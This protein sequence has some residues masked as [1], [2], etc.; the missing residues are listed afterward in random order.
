[1]T[2]ITSDEKRPLNNKRALNGNNSK[3]AK[4]ETESKKSLTGHLNIQNKIRKEANVN[5]KRPTFCWISFV[6]VP[7]IVN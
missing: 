5:R 2:Y 7:D 3:E 4:S 6:F 1:M